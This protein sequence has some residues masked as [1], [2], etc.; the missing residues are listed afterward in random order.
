[1]EKI[2]E[3]DLNDNEKEDFRKLVD[4][5]KKLIKSIKLQVNN[6]GKSSNL[7]NNNYIRFFMQNSINCDECRQSS[8]IN[9]LLNA[10]LYG[11]CTFLLLRI[12]LAHN[13]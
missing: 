12:I 9:F 4:S 8:L 2:V 1:M 7:G 5:V 10:G 6:S 11:C 3:L 13:N